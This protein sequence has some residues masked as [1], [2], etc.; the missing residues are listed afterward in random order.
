[1]TI[2]PFRALFCFSVAVTLFAA[3]SERGALLVRDEGCLECHS[4][5]GQG[6]GHEASGIAPDLANEIAAR[7]TAPALASAL[8]NHTPTMW[9][10]LSARVLAQPAADDSG[11]EDVFAYLYSLQFFELPAHS[12]RGQ[13]VFEA[14]GCAGCHS[15]REK[16]ASAGPPVSAWTKSDD[17][18]SLVYNM[19]RHGAQMEREIQAKE[20]EWKKL[21][22]QDVLDLTA[23]V[24]VVQG[25]PWGTSF[26]LPDPATGRSL[27]SDHCARCHNGPLSL[28][29]L[30]GN[31]TWM[32]LGAALWNHGS[33]AVNAQAIP[34]ADMRRIL[35]YAWQLQYMGPEGNV[36]RGET[37]FA[38][39]GCIS[40]HRTP[41]GRT[42]LRPKSGK[43]FTPFSMAALGWSNG[44]RMHQEMI[45]KGVA[46]PKLS[47][48][49]VS[50]I[51]AY[52]NTLPR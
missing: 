50:N 34:E 25:R 43:T 31:A 14:A 22:G 7:Y 2:H 18:V 49:D 6:A 48:E 30:V 12:R 26:T 29:K 17:P 40:C 11:W 39:K 45:Q 21:S 1:M 3:D 36:R 9:A 10:Q 41:D 23:Y 37:V 28:K 24:H 32:S 16:N 51:V 33:V 19:W 46:W 15:L 44:R 20:S 38:D 8:W 5:Q 4:V 47:A 42:P 35:A 13:E 52:L 27:F